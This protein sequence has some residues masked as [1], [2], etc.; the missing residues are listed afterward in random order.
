VYATAIA[1]VDLLVVFIAA[2]D[3]ADADVL[4]LWLYQIS[5]PPKDLLIIIMPDKLILTDIYY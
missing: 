5:P 4:L 2:A 3:A 1:F